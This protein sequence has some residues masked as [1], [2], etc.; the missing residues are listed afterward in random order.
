MV[1]NAVSAHRRLRNRAVAVHAARTGRAG[2][3]PRHA[4]PDGDA[5]CR[6]KLAR[7]EPRREDP[8]VLRE[9]LPIR[10]RPVDL[11]GRHGLGDHVAELLGT[12]QADRP[13]LTSTAKAA[14]SPVHEI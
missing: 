2:E 6:W 12:A 1:A 10:W 5:G 14:H 4:L 13:P 7:S 3:Q 8:A 11:L 9:R